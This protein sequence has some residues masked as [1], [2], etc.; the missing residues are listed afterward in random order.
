MNRNDIIC[1]SIFQSGR[2]IPDVV[3]FTLIWTELIDQINRA[4]DDHS[5]LGS[6]HES[7]HLLPP[8]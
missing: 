6:S 3:R 5:A 2:A 8:V 4:G 1:T 7:R